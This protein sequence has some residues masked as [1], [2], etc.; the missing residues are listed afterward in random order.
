MFLPPYQADNIYSDAEWYNISG[1]EFVDFINRTYDNMVHWRKNLL[2]L[3]A[4]KASRL[5]I[6][7]L[8]TWL[9][10]YNR[11]TPFKNIVLNVFMTLPGYKALEDR[12][13]LWNEGKIDMSVKE[14]RTIQNRFQNST[15]KKRA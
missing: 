5:F 15:N 12:L 9:D 11:N 7:E 6:N 2:K 3:P 14:A 10:L 13:K 8:T 4:G 1:K